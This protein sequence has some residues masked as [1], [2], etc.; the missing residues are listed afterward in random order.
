MTVNE[1]GQRFEKGSPR[2]S[3]QAAMRGKGMAPSRAE[4]V[5]VLREIFAFEVKGALRANVGGDDRPRQ[6]G[7]IVAVM[8]S[9]G[10]RFA[11]KGDRLLPS[12]KT[13][14]Q[15]ARKKRRV[16][17]L[18]DSGAGAHIWRPEVIPILEKKGLKLVRRERKGGG[19][20]I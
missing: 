2:C 11:F 13:S 16:V 20:K 12:K 19:E 5:H 9:R 15:G 17:R 3:R 8:V 1:G 18:Q 4:G 14:A 7:E 10:H 6:G